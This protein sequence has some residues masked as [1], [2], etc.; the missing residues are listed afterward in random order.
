MKANFL[1]PPACYSQKI[2]TAAPPRRRLDADTRTFLLRTFVKRGHTTNRAAF[3][4]I[5]SVTLHGTTPVEGRKMLGVS[6][7]RT[8]SDFEQG[9]DIISYK[10]DLENGSVSAFSKK[11][12][13]IPFNGPVK[14]ALVGELKWLIGERKGFKHIS[15]GKPYDVY[16]EHLSICLDGEKANYR[17]SQQIH[18]KVAELI[19]WLKQI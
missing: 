7:L 11:E 9:S 13:P 19:G 14:A 10:I 12:G 1:R 17:K 4:E 18:R 15:D 8:Y 2:S 16:L 5:K 6:V 3:I